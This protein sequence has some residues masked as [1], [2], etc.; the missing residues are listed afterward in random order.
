[1]IG[2]FLHDLGKIGIPDAILGKKEKL[3]DAEYEVIKSH[4]QTG[5]RMLAGH[6]PASLAND[7]MS[8]IASELGRQFDAQPGTF[9]LDLAKSGALLHIVEH[10]DEGIPLERCI[11]CGPIVVRLRDA[12]PEESLYCPACHSEYHLAKPGDGLV[13]TGRQDA[14]RALA[15]RPDRG[16]IAR[17]MIGRSWSHR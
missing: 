8:I 10:S 7:A 14:A 2:G 6:P 11:A 13:P 9:F 16:L 1:M 4:P 15:A 3:T 17:L 12:N 5:L